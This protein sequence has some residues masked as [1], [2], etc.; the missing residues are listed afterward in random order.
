MNPEMLATL[1]AIM[2]AVIGGAGGFAALMK[3]NADNSRTVSEGAVNVVKMVRDELASQNTRLQAVEQ[4]MGEMEV[5]SERVLTL[6]EKAIDAVPEGRKEPFR[7][8]H[9]A[10]AQARPRRRVK[11]VT[12]AA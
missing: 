12:S 3:V 5:W 9:E 10:L 4:Y 1:G 8:E 11:V 7:I 6:T 2:V